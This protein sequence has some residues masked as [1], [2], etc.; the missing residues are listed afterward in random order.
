M[1]NIDFKDP[2][3]EVPDN[4]PIEKQYPWYI[5]AIRA[6]GGIIILLIALYGFMFALDMM[7]NSF[8]IL[9]GKDASKV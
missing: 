3:L 7:S 1:N 5:K 6:A 8:R 4:L 9:G 2:T